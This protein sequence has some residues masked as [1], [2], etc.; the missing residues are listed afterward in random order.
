MGPRPRTCLWRP[1]GSAHPTSHCLS[2]GLYLLVPSLLGAQRAAPGSGSP[3]RELSLF[4]VGTCSS[5]VAAA[6]LRGL[7]HNHLWKLPP[8]LAAC[9]SQPALRP[10]GMSASS[11]S[12][13][14]A[15]GQTKEPSSRRA[16][17]SAQNL[18]AA[19]E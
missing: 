18:E 14:T 15:A 13:N 4:C 2:E 12:P 1:L 6:C 3:E 10:A 16:R 11:R 19:G 8:T 5:W 7:L 9:G 17:L